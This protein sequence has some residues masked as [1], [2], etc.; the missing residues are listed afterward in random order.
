M[1]ISGRQPFFILSPSWHDW[2]SQGHC[3]VEL[4][5]CQSHSIQ[6]EGGEYQLALGT[7]LRNFTVSPFQITL[8]N[9]IQLVPLAATWLQGS[10]E[11]R[12]FFKE[13]VFSVNI[14]EFGY[15]KVKVLVTRLC[16]T[17]HDPMECSLPGS[18]VHGI[19]QTR[20]LE[21]VAI[22]LSRGSSRPR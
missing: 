7:C 1:F 13:A 3:M 18:S 14:L 12:F 8:Q 11:N 17:M 10:L 22:S 4:Q 15:Q 2:H 9:C 6:Q 16:P 20:I 19:L 21:W 5:L